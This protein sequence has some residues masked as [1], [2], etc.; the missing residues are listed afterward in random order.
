MDWCEIIHDKIKYQYF[1]TFGSGKLP[2]LTND[3]SVVAALK[4]IETPAD[5]PA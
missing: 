5:K 1:I 3:A 2:T 4:K